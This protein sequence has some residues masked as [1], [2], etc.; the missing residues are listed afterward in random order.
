[1][2]I[3]WTAPADGPDPEEY[4]VYRSNLIGSNLR[5]IATVPAEST[6][7]TDDTVREE[8]W[9]AYRVRAA[10]SQ[11]EG[12]ESIQTRVQTPGVPNQ[13]TETTASED[14]AG[15]VVITW[16]A[17]TDGPD[18]TGYKVYRERI[19]AGGERGKTQV[20]TTGTETSFTDETV[21][22]EVMYI[23][24]VRAK[25]DA[26]HGSESNM[27]FITTGVQNDAAPPAP[28]DTSADQ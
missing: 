20:G 15:E 1:M 19:T 2:V 9:Y 16:T 24:T 6:T 18:P 7:Y 8:R 12:P 14:T 26:G 23:Y 25:N 10:N 27:A 17:P 5:Q 13:P 11:A 3:S 22:P 21:A 4:R 28:E